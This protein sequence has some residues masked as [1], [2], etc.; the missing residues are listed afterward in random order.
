MCTGIRM[1]KI[2]ELERGD[3]IGK[4]DIPGPLNPKKAFPNELPFTIGEYEVRWRKTKGNDITVTVWDNNEGVARLELIPHTA[5]GIPT[6]HV[7]AVGLNSEYQG[8]GIGYELYKGLLKFTSL[9]LASV[10]VQSP[11][12]RKLW[13]RLSQDPQVKA[14]GIDLKRNRWLEV[15]PNSAGTEL[16]SVKGKPS[17]YS[18]KDYGILLVKRNSKTDKLIAKMAADSEEL[19]ADIFGVKQHKR[20]YLTPKDY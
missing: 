6:Y 8:Q 4:D 18:S 13:A 10:G 20:K 19:P 16:M 3:W 1:K 12:A 17:L 11:G 15:K 9:N 5:M 7:D 14:W 2:N